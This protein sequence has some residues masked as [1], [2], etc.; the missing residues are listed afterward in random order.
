MYEFELPF[1]PS[2]NTYRACVRNRLI[3]SKKGRE[4][5]KEVVQCMKDLG[6]E[7]EGLVCRLNVS[8]ILY[9]P[10]K[11][12]RDL[13]NYNKALLDGISESGFWEDDSQIDTL[14][15]VRGEKVKGGKVRILVLENDIYD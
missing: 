1:P 8:I 11:R 5:K 15:I 7:G 12:K 10:C 4:Y 9:P 6:L 3:T 14:K 13:D 2:L